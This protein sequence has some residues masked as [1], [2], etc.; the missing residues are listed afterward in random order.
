[1]V[2]NKRAAKK[3]GLGANY[4]KAGQTVGLG[5]VETQLQINR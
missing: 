5:G 4:Y 1:M 2:P 3:N